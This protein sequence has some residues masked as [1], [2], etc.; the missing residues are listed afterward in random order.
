[1]R[2]ATMLEQENALPSPELHPSFNNWHSLAR[3]GQDHADVRRHVIATFG[4]VSEVIG[5]FRHQPIEEFFQVAPCGRIGILHD[6]HAATGVL[7]KDRHRPIAQPAVVD[8][9]LDVVGDFVH[10]LATGADFESVM[11]YAHWAH[12]IQRG[13]ESNVAGILDS[14]ERRVTNPH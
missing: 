14:L 4:T 9:C 1:M 10:S 5:I 8:L 12:V 11:V 7:N 2:G 6:D 13:D 3:A